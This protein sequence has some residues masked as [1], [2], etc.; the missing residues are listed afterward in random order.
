[1]NEEKLK[2]IVKAKLMKKEAGLSDSFMKFIEKFDIEIPSKE[3]ARKTLEK[4]TEEDIKEAYKSLPKILKRFLLKKG[5]NELFTDVQKSIILFIC[6]ISL[7]GGIMPEN[8]TAAEKIVQKEKVVMKQEKKTERG[9]Y[10]G[11]ILT[12]EALKNITLEDSFDEALSKI[13]SGIKNKEIAF[14]SSLP[15]GRIK[16]YDTKGKQLKNT[17]ELL[18]FDGNYLTLNK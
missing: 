1:M 3:K 16:I 17:F 9:E 5:S 4:Y 6:L 13:K 10:L 8:P 15:S 2:R 7:A 12:T 11:R 18:N 14:N